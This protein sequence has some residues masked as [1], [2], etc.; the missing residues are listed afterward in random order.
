[1]LGD[2][3]GAGTAFDAHAIIV[4]LISDELRHVTLCAGVLQAL[5]ATARLPEPLELQQPSAFLDMPAAARALAI[6]IAQLVVNETLS[7]AYIEDLHARCEQPAIAAVLRA[8]L[9]DEAGHDAFGVEYV[10]RALA[11]R[12]QAELWRWRKLADDALGPQR[13]AAQRVLRELGAAERDLRAWPDEQEVALGLFT[14]QRQALVFQ[15]AYDERLA[16]RLAL[17][18]LR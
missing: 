13:E 9:S 12:P 14:P 16:P 11:E 8:T 10:Q 1:L 3:L 4:E 7:V 15:Q 5:G 6:A 2:A 17:L 18:G